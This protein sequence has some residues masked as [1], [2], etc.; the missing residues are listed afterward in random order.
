LINVFLASFD[1]SAFPF[2]IFGCSVKFDCVEMK[3]GGF[4]GALCIVLVTCLATVE[5]WFLWGFWGNFWKDLEGSFLWK[6][7]GI[8]GE[9]FRESFWGFWVKF[10]EIVDKFGGIFSEVS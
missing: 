3:F 7:Y 5:G 4:V 2:V 9:A 6:F 1:Q 8:A 10:E